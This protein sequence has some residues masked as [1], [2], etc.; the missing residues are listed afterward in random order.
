MAVWSIRRALNTRHG[1]VLTYS[2]LTFIIY[3][4]QQKHAT[5][6]SLT[7]RL[8]FTESLMSITLPAFT[9]NLGSLFSNWS[10]VSVLPVANSMFKSE[11]NSL[12]VNLK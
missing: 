11:Q 2:I 3:R 5:D 12:G 9:N 6:L 10:I 4:Y 8:A 1:H 7:C